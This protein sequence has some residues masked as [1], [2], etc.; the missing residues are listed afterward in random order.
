MI[1]KSGL[2][3]AISLCLA[4]FA[5]SAED[6]DNEPLNSFGYPDQNVVM[7]IEANEK[8]DSEGE[9]VNMPDC[10]NPDLLAQL[11]ELLLP[12]LDK[13]WN[14]IRE[15]RKIDLTMKNIRNFETLNLSEIDV[16]KDTVVADRVMELKINQKKRA[17]DIKICK[18]DSKVIGLPVYTLMYYEGENLTVEVLNFTAKNN[19]KFVFANQN[20]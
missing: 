20:K 15:R 1:N 11:K 16:K 17:S 4:P 13:G 2:L 19:P 6:S 14:N 5:V 7:V 10:N 3:F 12:Y 9:S 18:V 8:A